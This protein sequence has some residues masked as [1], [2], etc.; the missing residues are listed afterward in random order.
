MKLPNAE[1]AY[2]PLPKLTDYLLSETHA[3]GR[4]KAAFFYKIGFTR[5]RAEDLRV[6]LLGLARTGDVTDVVETLYGMKYVVDGELH[7]PMGESI[8]IR[9][10]WIV[11]KGEEWPRFV[12]AYAQKG[13]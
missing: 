5:E 4:A 7:A 6:A 13:E 11:E 3:I 9:T 2:I 1:R 10:V 8:K 12:T